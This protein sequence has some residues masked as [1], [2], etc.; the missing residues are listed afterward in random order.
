MSVYWIRTRTIMINDRQVIFNYLIKV[1]QKQ[2]PFEYP[3]TS[4]PN[5]KSRPHSLNSRLISV[6]NSWQFQTNSR[7]RYDISQTVFINPTIRKYIT[8]HKHTHVCMKPKPI[9]SDLNELYI[10][11]PTN[12]VNILTGGLNKLSDNHFILKYQPISRF[13]WRAP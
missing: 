11:K 13:F 9:N 12:N 10:I 6:Q 8:C 5:Y 7:L 3:I 2:N 1:P 4:V